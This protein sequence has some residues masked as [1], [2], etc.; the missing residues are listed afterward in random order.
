MNG[1]NACVF[2]LAKR[3]PDARGVVCDGEGVMLGA[4]P[5]IVPLPDATGR[6][7]YRVARP[8]WVADVLATAYGSGFDVALARRFAQLDGIA[9]ALGEG[10]LAEAAIRAVHL[11]LPELTAEGAARL[12]LLRKYSPDQPRVPKGNPDGGQWTSG[13]GSG[14]SSNPLLTLASATTDTSAPPQIVCPVPGMQIRGRDAYGSG[15]FGAPRDAGA[16]RHPG[17]DLVAPPGTPV[18]SP[19]SG[20]VRNFDPYRADADKRGHFHGVE[21]TTK[22][23]YRVRVMYVD[24]GGLRGGQ[25]IKAG[26]PLGSAE[27]LS[28]VY[29]PKR[30][31]RMTNHVHLDIKDPSGRFIDPTPL[32]T[33]CRQPNTDF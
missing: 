24:G 22:D 21:I 11:Q 4:A 3:A 27:D 16:R 19:V 33:R 17:V 7:R 1:P 31:G 29:P 10:R 23:G 2:T 18:H 15:A 5:L 30:G 20:T 6:R 9:K 26:D 12:A 14:A 28:S 25:Y 8:E 32:M 13:S